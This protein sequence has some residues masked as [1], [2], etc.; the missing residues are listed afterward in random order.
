MTNERLTELIRDVNPVTHEP[1]RPVDV[2]WGVIV[3]AHEDSRSTP[4]P[5]RH[6]TSALR[7][8]PRRLLALVAV[9]LLIAGVS[10]FVSVQGSNNRPS[11]TNVIARAFGVVNA[12]A[13]TAGGFSTVP[14]TP[15]GF[16]RLT[17]PTSEVCYLESTNLVGSGGSSVTKIYKTT[18]SGT[19]WTPLAI[20]SVGSANTAFSCSNISV[21]S[22]GFIDAPSTSHTGQFARGT[23]QSILT[24]TDGGIT[25]KRHVVRIPPVLGDDTALDASLT[26]VQGQ[27][28]QLQCFSAR[29]CIAVAEVPSDQPQE[30]FT[31]GNALGVLR[32]VIMRTDARRVAVTGGAVNRDVFAKRIMVAD[33]GAGDAALPFQILSLQPDA[34]ER[35]NFISFSQPGVPVNDHVRM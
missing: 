23:L 21:C 30:P 10:A 5:S 7:M 9:I 26:D 20:P 19:N 3:S 22:V 29:S 18:D 8:K 12:N 2:A 14:S 31:N 34:G 4:T 35:E 25:W 32:N 1:S 13:A 33:F 15:Q 24:T 16:N 28:S 11:L 17:C 6:R 27:W